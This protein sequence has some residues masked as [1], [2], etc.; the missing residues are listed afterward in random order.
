MQYYSSDSYGSSLDDFMFGDIIINLVISQLQVNTY[1][2]SPNV[3]DQLYGMPMCV[4]RTCKENAGRGWFDSWTAEPTE[5][6]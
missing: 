1:V 4:R 6:V 3:M 5:I 2:L